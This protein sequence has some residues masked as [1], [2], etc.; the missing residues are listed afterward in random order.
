M[1]NRAASDEPVLRHAADE[2]GHPAVGGEACLAYIRTQ[3]N[4]QANMRGSTISYAA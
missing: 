3:T 1:A 4:R 2:G